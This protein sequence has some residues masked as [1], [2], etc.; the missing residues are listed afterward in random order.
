MISCNGFNANDMN[1]LVDVELTPVHFKQRVVLHKV[2][3]RVIF[4]NW[5]ETNIIPGTILR[6]I[7]CHAWHATNNVCHLTSAKVLV[8]LQVM[9]PFNFKPNTKMYGQVG[10]A[11]KT[12]TS[13]F[14]SNFLSKYVTEM[15]V[16]KKLMA[17]LRLINRVKS[18]GHLSTSIIIVILVVVVEYTVST[19][20][21]HV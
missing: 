1:I 9:F 3:F 4:I 12:F 14:T 16:K 5:S 19:L 11:W 10:C 20:R 7:S 13:N 17:L 6:F 21:F 2:N 18:K 15:K 8:S